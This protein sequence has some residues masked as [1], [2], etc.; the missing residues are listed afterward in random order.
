MH[1]TAV[2]SCRVIDCLSAWTVPMS[3][4]MHT[5]VWKKCL[6]Y[7]HNITTKVCLM[8][9]F[10]TTY[11][12]I[13]IAMLILHAAENKLDQ[14]PFFRISVPKLKS[15]RLQSVFRLWSCQPRTENFSASIATSAYIKIDASSITQNGCH[16]CLFSAA[17][18]FVF[19]SEATCA[20]QC[21]LRRYRFHE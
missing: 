21:K 11:V 17:T 9:V 12:I 16:V 2:S 6:L 18:S 20:S 4:F 7:V 19:S 3:R 15:R 13:L 14:I 10:S 8:Y 1:M 5:S